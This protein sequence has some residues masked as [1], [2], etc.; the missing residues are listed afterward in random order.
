MHVAFDP[1]ILLPGI[2]PTDTLPQVPSDVWTMIFV[3]GVV[4]N[5]KSLE[6]APLSPRGSGEIILEAVANIY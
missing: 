3:C 4:Y 1:A 6:T 2:F 5:N